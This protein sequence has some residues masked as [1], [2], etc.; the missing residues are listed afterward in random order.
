M[1]NAIFPA[2]VKGLT[3]TILKTAE[4][5]SISQESPNGYS[6]RIA[7]SSNPIWHLQLVWDYVYDAYLSLN[8]TQAYAPYTD[9]QTLMGFFL[10][11][12]GKFDDFLLLDPNDFSAGG[13]RAST[14]LSAHQFV[15]GSVV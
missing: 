13:I 14:W 11:R 2:N 7:Q 3:Y 15:V 1:S 10:A 6:L 9:L 5:K 4:F 12:R 8:N